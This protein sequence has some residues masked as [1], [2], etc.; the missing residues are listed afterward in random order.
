MVAGVGGSFDLNRVPKE[1]LTE[2]GSVKQRPERVS[3]IEI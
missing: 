2:K 3:A 1:S